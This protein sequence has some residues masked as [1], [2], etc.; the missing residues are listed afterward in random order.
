MIK[1]NKLLKVFGFLYLYKEFIEWYFYMCII[2]IFIVLFKYMY[3][4]LCRIYEI[5][6]CLYLFSFDCLV[7][8]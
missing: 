6:G 8:V 3:F 5:F 4:I 7:K 1:I 2:I